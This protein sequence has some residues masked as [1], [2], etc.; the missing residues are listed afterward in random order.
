MSRFVEL[1]LTS[2]LSCVPLADSFREAR[3]RGTS[4]KLRRENAGPVGIAS[5]REC[6]GGPPRTGR[7]RTVTH[8]AKDAN[9]ESTRSTVR[10]DASGLLPKTCP[11][12]HSLSWGGATARQGGDS[13][14][15]PFPGP[16]SCGVFPDPKAG[17][18]ANIATPRSVAPSRGTRARKEQ[19]GRSIQ[20]PRFSHPRARA[21]RA[22]S[23]LSSHRLAQRPAD[24]PTRDFPPAQGLGQ[25]GG[26]DPE[27][28]MPTHH[29]PL[30]QPSFVS[31]PPDRFDP[32]AM[33]FR[34]DASGDRDVCPPFDFPAS[35]LARAARCPTAAAIGGAPV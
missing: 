2:R 26:R 22:C 5:Y 7:R 19:R 30:P 3:C 16:S 35:P 23:S 27:S 13:P 1:P 25:K 4:R 17:A 29:N 28:A 21:A 24:R 20:G 10:G 31:V 15:G 9:A 32:G 12:P 6:Q 34:V 14:N 11:A 18:A 8:H 33:L